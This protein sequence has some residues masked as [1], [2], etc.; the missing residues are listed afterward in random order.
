MVDI[1]K[2]VVYWRLSAAEDWDVAEALVERGNPRHGLFFAHLALE[3][4]AKGT[5][6]CTHPRVGAS[7][8]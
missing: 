5:S 4:N 1:E 3:K 7:D 2:Q 6:Q 8:P